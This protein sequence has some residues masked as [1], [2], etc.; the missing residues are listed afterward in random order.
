LKKVLLCDAD[1]T[2][3]DS[4]EWW[5]EAL[6]YTAGVLGFD[7]PSPDELHDLVIAT[8]SLSAIYRACAPHIEPKRCLE[9]HRAHQEETIDMVKL[10]EGVFKT[11]HGLHEGGVRLAI[12]TNRR[13]REP[14]INTL[15]K[16]GLDKILSVIVCDED[17]RNPKPDPEGILL[18]LE[19]LGIRESELDRDNTYIVGDNPIDIEA[20]K[21]ASIKTIGVLYSSLGEKFRRE[22]ADHYVSRFSEVLGIVLS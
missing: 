5:D 1:G 20:G 6:Y 18:A 17:V 21:R 2:I 3:L 8:S 9:V 13:P 12:V 22:G 15:R 7:A 11:L 4:A 14:L 10:Y 16:Y 19:R